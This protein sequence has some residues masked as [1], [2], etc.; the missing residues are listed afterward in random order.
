MLEYFNIFYP[1]GF[2]G[3]STLNY[4]IQSILIIKRFPTYNF[5]Y[6]DDGSLH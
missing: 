2:Y 3:I 5:I 1:I 4:L 6:T